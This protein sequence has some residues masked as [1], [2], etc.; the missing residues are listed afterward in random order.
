MTPHSDE[1]A[2]A[3]QLFEAAR[4]ERPPAGARRRALQKASRK[5]RAF[6]LE[7]WFLVA[8]A[9]GAAWVVLVRVRAVE[10][11]EPA[12]SAEP[13]PAAP[14]PVEALQQRAPLST[15]SAVPEPPSS[16]HVPPRAPAPKPRV[17]TL[18][19]ELAL[20][21]RARQTLLQGDTAGALQ[22]LAHYDKVAT[23]RRLGAEATLLRIQVLAA[24]GRSAEASERASAFV[25]Q[26]PN[27]PLAERAQSF[28][29]TPAPQAPEQEHEGER[30]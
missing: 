13:V 9:L 8:A 28:I 4:R 18:E 27:S 14:G 1:D 15:V 30:P 23:E 12:I 21:D 3:E 7:R 19:E 20:L 22:S 10:P 2:F 26:H 25:R 29:A 11:A 6:R 16:A 24:A 17:V 5:P